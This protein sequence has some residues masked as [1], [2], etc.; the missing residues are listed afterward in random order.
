MQYKS[1][2]NSEDIQCSVGAIF[3]LQKI[4]K[5]PIE[6]GLVPICRLMGS[7]SFLSINSRARTNTLKN[8]ASVS[9][10]VFVF[11]NEG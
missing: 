8:I 4:G 1:N 5:A 2:R 3:D 7:H 10:P 6:A 9:T 11:C